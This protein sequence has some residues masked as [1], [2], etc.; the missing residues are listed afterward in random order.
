MSDKR[1]MHQE[2]TDRIIEQIETGLANGKDWN[3][4][5][6]SMTAEG[7]PTNAVTH[8][9]YRGV[10]II[11][12]W[13]SAQMQGCETAQWATYRQWQSI[14]ANVRK[15]EK[16][17]RIVFYKRLTVKDRDSD[18]DKDTKTIPLLR[19]STVFNGDQVDDWTKRPTPIDPPDVA[20]RIEELDAYVANTGAKIEENGGSAHYVHSSKP[21]DDHAQYVEHWLRMLRA[22]KKAIFTAAARAS[23]AVA[24]IEGLQPD[25]E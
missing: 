24:Y 4:P 11:Q 21:R 18:D 19:Y 2:I 22:D 9:P 23:D 25:T 20:E 6:I 14:G 1:D 17:T 10:N 3:P 7:I 13:A 12:L 8:K 5:W 16:G 15:G